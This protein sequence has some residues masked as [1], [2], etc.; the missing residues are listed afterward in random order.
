MGPVLV[1]VRVLQGVD[2]AELEILRGARLALPGR[3]ILGLVDPD[4][5]PLS[6]AAAG[7]LDGVCTTPHVARRAGPEC[8]VP[9]APGADPLFAAGLLLDPALPSIAPERAPASVLERYW[10]SRVDVVVPARRL[11]GEAGA[12][13]RREPAASRLAVLSTAVDLPVC[14]SL[15]RRGADVFGPERLASLSPHYGHVLFVLDNRPESGTL[16]RWLRRFGG[17]ALLLDSCLL[18]AYGDAEAAALA[19]RELGRAVPKTELDQWR[20][21][22]ARPGA[23]LLGEVAEAADELFVHSAWLAEEIGRRFGRT[24]TVVPPVPD[25]PRVRAEAGGLQ[26][27]SCVW[28]VEMLRS[29]GR[30][31]RLDLACPAAEAPALEGLAARLG[32]GEAVAFAPGAAT[33]LLFLA[34]RGHGSLSSRL[35]AAAGLPCIASRG[36]AEA[37]DSAGVRIVP[38]QPSPPLLA[39]AIL[40]ALPDAASLDETARRIVRAL[41]A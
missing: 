32:V 38:D 18:A 6:A 13:R 12:L 9:L 26:A 31:I 30:D 36:V 41:G 25:L 2:G 15:Q 29:W 28:A 14:R 20:A 8:F 24:A 16:I 39:E 35:M 3:A 1:D 27:E 11:W 10:Q 19:A 21:G 17:S 37:V 22:I 4:L 5:P 23:L 7:C 40:A 33:V 34:M